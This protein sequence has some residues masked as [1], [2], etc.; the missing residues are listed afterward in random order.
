MNSLNHLQMLGV[1]G[2][3][4]SQHQLLA[5]SDKNKGKQS[6]SIDHWSENNILVNMFVGVSLV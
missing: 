2:M 6:L 4:L 3:S 5:T 1:H